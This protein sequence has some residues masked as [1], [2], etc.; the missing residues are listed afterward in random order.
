MGSNRLMCLNRRVVIGLIDATAVVYSARALSGNHTGGAHVRPDLATAGRRV[1]I[2]TP[3]PSQRNAPSANI[4]RRPALAGMASIIAVGVLLTGCADDAIDSA[5]SSGGRTGGDFHSLVADPANPDRIYV[6]GHHAVSV[7]NDGGTTWSDVASLRDADAMGWAFVDG[8]IYVAGHPGLNRS[9]DKGDTFD[10]TN[11]GL[12]TTDVHA[13]GGA[14][15][16]IYGAGPGG[17]FFTGTPDRGW[18]Q[19]NPDVGHGFFGR[20]LVDATDTDRVYAAGPQAGIAHSNDGGRAWQ[21]LAS[22]LPSILWLSAP[23][24]D[25]ATIV[26]SG[27]DGAA[28]SRD[29]GATWQTLQIPE[30]VSLVEAA[31]GRPGLLYAGRHEG[32]HVTIWISTDGG[33]TWTEQ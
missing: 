27:P 31:P 8:Y 2:R 13:L 7:S 11:E 33:D 6:G 23:D 28:L 25:L 10:Q 22:P 18:E 26:A 3:R 1:K 17:G 14:G 30:G 32:E 9:D 5:E 15:S 21:L 19:R 4:S 29:D 16:T 12:P 20:I 24:P